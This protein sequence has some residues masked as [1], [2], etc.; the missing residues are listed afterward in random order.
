PPRR[1]LADDPAVGV[2]LHVPDAGRAAQG[3]LVATLDPRLP[4]H[5]AGRVSLE[6]RASELVLRDLAD[7]A[8]EVGHGRAVRVPPLRAHVDVDAGEEEPPLL[9]RRYL[10]EREVGRNDERLAGRAAATRHQRVDA[11]WRQTEQRRESLQ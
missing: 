6:F 7:V 9:D 2:H 3:P 8:E 1:V 5:L 10:L 11:S 4:D